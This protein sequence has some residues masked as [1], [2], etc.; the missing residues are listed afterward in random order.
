MD[1]IDLSIRELLDHDGM[2][3][4]THKFSSVKQ[5][6][7]GSFGKI[8]KVKYLKSNKEAALKVCQIRSRNSREYLLNESFIL[9]LLNNKYFPRLYH[10]CLFKNIFLMEFEYIEGITLMEY[11]E[12]KG[13]LVESEILMI[14]NQLIEALDHIHSNKIVHRDIK[15]ENIIINDKMQI[16]ICDFGFARLFKNNELLMDYCGSNHYCSPEILEGRAYEGSKNDIWT[17]G[18]CILLLSIG[19]EK[20]YDLIEDDNF[21][22]LAETNLKDV[23]NSTLIAS[24]LEQILRKDFRKR[25]SLEAIKRF[26][27]VEKSRSESYLLTILDPFVIYQMINRGIDIDT[28]LK[29]ISNDDSY[30]NHVYRFHE[31]ELYRSLEFQ[32]NQEHEAFGIEILMNDIKTKN[33]WICC[34]IRTVFEL[35]VQNDISFDELLKN[36]PLRITNVTNKQR[37]RRIKILDHKIE[38]GITKYKENIEFQDYSEKGL[39]F[40]AVI[41]IIIRSYQTVRI[42][43][44]L[45]V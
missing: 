34:G 8:Y 12:K 42:R 14:L 16:K 20:F 45:E 9:S 6:G 29:R 17:L 15:L 28:I 13:V 41:S 35:Q 43:N 26:I 33:T 3:I 27:R 7:E 44:I 36:C 21:V 23:V 32:M 22:S 25:L 1:E 11:L 2:K 40:L 24:L 30:E 19:N 39:E 4:L 38:I 10:Y 31:Q 18:V 37:Y 5:I